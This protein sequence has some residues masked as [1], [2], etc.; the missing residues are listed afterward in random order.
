MMKLN[1]IKEKVLLI[2]NPRNITRRGVAEN[3]EVDD[4]CEQ[5]SN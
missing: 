3:G 4:I 1:H 5:Y 2:A